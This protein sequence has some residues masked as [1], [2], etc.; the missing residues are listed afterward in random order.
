M[1][2]SSGMVLHPV[3]CSSKLLQ[4]WQSC[5]RCR[6]RRSQK[7]STDYFPWHVKL[8]RK[9]STQPPEGRE[10]NSTLAGLVATPLRLPARYS[11][12]PTLLPPCY[13][14]LRRIRTSYHA[15]HCYLLDCLCQC[16]CH[17]LVT[18]ARLRNALLPC[19]IELLQ[20]KLPAS[21]LVMPVGTHTLSHLQS[22]G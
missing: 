11:R 3:L 2:V 22:T 20:Q 4:C 14:N 19:C 6:H 9:I 8:C 18:F 21:Q 16:R 10:R 15:Y 12:T 13:C 1:P 17:P 7:G 5:M